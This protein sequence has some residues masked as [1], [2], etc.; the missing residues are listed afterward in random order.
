VP[1]LLAGLLFAFLLSEAAPLDPAEAI[2]NS[3]RGNEV[4]HYSRAARWNE[5]LNLRHKFGLGLPTFY[6]SIASAAE[7]DTLYR[8]VL[9][10][11][12]SALS[13]LI[14]ANGNWNEISRYYASVQKLSDDYYNLLDKYPYNDSLLQLNEGINGLFLQYNKEQIECSITALEK[15]AKTYGLLREGLL[16]ADIAYKAI[17]SKRTPWKA[18]IP[19]IH[20]H[21]FNNRFDL[22]VWH[23]LKGDFGI[24]YADRRPVAAI[25]KEAIPY[26]LLLN[27]CAILLAF[28]L[29]VPLGIFLAV[30]N[31]SFADRA[32]T[33][34]LFVLYSLPV[35]WIATLLIIYL[36]GGDY[37]NVFPSSGITD[38]PPNAPLSQK[39]P[40]IA[41]HL[42]LPVTCLVYGSFAYIS[43]QVKSSMSGQLRQDYI[44]TA[45]AK[46]LAEN[47]IVLKH[48]F[49]NALLPVITLIASILPALING[50]VVVE[51][52]FSI[53]GMGQKSFA[54]V[55]SQDYPLIFSVLVLS[56]LLTMLGNLAADM[57]YVA[58]DPR[59]SFTSN[60]GD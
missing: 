57:L 54:A 58:A 36:G 10:G 51:S 20:I 17:L 55:Q 30:K 37:L 38:L 6:F 15:E 35:F 7:P 26:T 9:A 25:L 13:R 52:I 41:W 46:G 1:T 42:V 24:S 49:R 14:R 47:T 43:R 59:I 31:K 56:I 23:M 18:Y 16:N 29:S 45:R 40:D 21:G 2:L 53:P 8:V 34:T 19:V 28:L 44:R 5:Y 50:S 27:G 60:K 32:I 39:L 4:Q 33:T 22:W 48:A 12:R 3:D 11:R